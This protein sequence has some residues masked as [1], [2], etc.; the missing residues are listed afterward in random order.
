MTARVPH[1]SLKQSPAKRRFTFYIRVPI[2]FAIA[3]VIS[4][5]AAYAFPKPQISS[6]SPTSGPVGTSVPISGKNF[7][8]SQMNSR[9]GVFNGTAAT[10]SS[11]TRTTIV[12]SVPSAA[13]TGHV[14]VE[15]ID[16]TSNGG[17][18]GAQTA[19]SIT[20]L[21]PTSGPVGSSVTINGSNFGSSQGSSTVTF[22]GT[23]ATTID[24]WGS[25]Q[26]VAVVPTG[27]TTGNVVVTVGGTASNGVAFTLLGT[28]TITSLSPTSAGVGTP[29][30][31]KGT[32]FGSSQNSSTVTFNGTEA[33]TIN[34]WSGT[35]IV[36]VVPAEATTGDVV[37]TLDGVVSSNGVLF[38]LLTTPS[39]TSLSPTSGP[40]GHYVTITGKALGP[41]QG[42]ST[43]T[44]NGTTATTFSSWS[45]TSIVTFVP[46]GA[47]TGDVVVTVN[48][49]ASNG[50]KFTVLPTPNITSLSPK[51]GAI[52]TVVTIS[53]TEFGSTQGSSTVTFNGTPGTPS[54]WGSTSIKVA[55]P[56]GASSGMVLVTVGGIGSNGVLFTIGTT[57]SLTSLSPTSGP[58][59]APVT[60]TGTNFGSVQ[61]NSQVTFN[62]V[63]APVTSWSPTQ[64]TAQVP[65]LAT[66]G[67]VVVTVL[68]FAS[69]GI[70]FTV[71][72][73][74]GPS[75]LSVAPTAGLAGSAVAIT[76]S[77]FGNTQG[78][79]TVTFNGAA[80]TPT[81]W[82]SGFIMTTVPNGATSGN[83]V[84]TYGGVASNG[85]PYTVGAAPII[86]TNFGCCMIVGQNT[87][88]AG[89][90][91]GSS[92]GSSTI[93]VNG[94]AV[95]P[96]LW[97]NTD[98]NFKVPSNVVLGN[99]NTLV[100][101]VNGLPSNTVYFSIEPNIT[102]IT[103][104]AANQSA[105]VTINGTSFGATQGASSVA[106]G[107]Q[108]YATVTSWSNTSIVATV[109][110]SA[111]S[112]YADVQINGV[113]TGGSVASNYFPFIVGSPAPNITSLNPSS[114]PPLSSVTINGTNFLTY[115]GKVTFN[116]VSATTTNWT[117]T[118][119]TATVPSTATTGNVVVD[120]SGGGDNSNG[121]LFTVTSTPYI[122][123]LNPS[124]GGIGS[125]IEIQG[126]N[127]GSTQG[128]STV[129]VNGTVLP[130]SAITSWYNTAVYFTVPT[131]ATSG[132]VVVTV[133][134]VASN[135]VALTINSAPTIT[136]LENSEGYI[137]ESI[138]IVGYSFGATQGSST[139][140]FSGTS[141][142]VTYWS[143]TYIYA[144]V[145]NG[146]AIGTSNIV[147]TVGGVSSNS[148]PLT[149]IPSITSFSPTWGPVGTTV[150]VTGTNFGSTQGSSTIT[151]NSTTGTP[152]SWANTKIVVPVPTGATSGYVHVTESSL[153]SNYQ[154][155]YVGSAPTLTSI[156]PT[157]GPAGLYVTLTGTNFG[158]GGSVSFNGTTTS[159]YSQNG[160]S[161]VVAVPAGATTGNVTITPTG[162]VASNAVTFTV[163][164]G[165]GIT[166][167]NSANGNT[168]PGGG[169]GSSASI[170]GAGFGTSQGSSTVTFNG[171]SATPTYWNTSEIT[172][173]VPAGA[174]TGN[175][176]VTVG[177]I[178]S[179]AIAFTIYADPTVTSVSPTAA[180]PPASVTIT[181]NNF[182]ASQGNSYLCVPEGCPFGTVTSWSN[183]QI[184]VPISAFQLQAYG[185]GAPFDVTVNVDT[186]S[187]GI[188]SNGV[189]LTILP[190]ASITTI[191]PTSG[192][193]GT[194]VT[195]T[196]LGFGTTQS[197][198]TVSFNGGIATP[199]AWS[200]NSITV[201]VPAGAIAGPVIVTVNGVPANAPSNFSPLPV[202]TSISPTS[203]STNQPVTISG[204]GFG[205]A[206]NAG[207]T[208]GFYGCPG[209]G[210]NFTN[211][212][213]HPTSWSSTQIT[214]PVPNNAAT[215]PVSVY[216]CGGTSNSVNFTVPPNTSGTI[217][218][219]VTNALTTAAVAGITVA[220]QQSGSTVASV[221]T[222]TNGTYSLNNLQP[223]TYNIQGTG[224]GYVTVLITGATVTT[225]NTTTVNLVLS[226]APLVNSITPAWGGTGSVV[227]ISGTNFGPSQADSTGSVTFNGVSATPSSWNNSTITVPVPAS[228]T[229]GPTVVT[230]GGVL[231]NG[232]TFNVGGGSIGGTVTNAANGDAVSGAS[233]QALLAHVVQGTATTTSSGAYTIANLGPGT[234][235][236]V[237]SATGLGASVTTGE[238][239]TVGNTT[240]VNVALPA[241]GTDSGTVT[242]G[243]TGINNA[244]VSALRDGDAIATTTTSSSGSFT[245]ANLGAGTYSIEAAATGYTPET[246]NGVSITAGD[247]TTTNFALSGQTTLIYE[248]DALGR[249]AGVVDSLKGSGVYKYDAV[250][251]LTSIQRLS[252]SQVSVVS[253]SPTA[254]IAGTTV[255]ISGTN[256]SSTPSQDSV[257]FNG[258]GATVSAATTT[259]LTVTVPSAATSGA[260]KVT[261]PAGSGTSS[262]SFT[263]WTSSNNPAPSI[264]AIS[265]TLAA[266]GQTVTIT[267]TNFDPNS[268]NDGILLD[269][270]FPVTTASATPTTLTFVVPLNSPTGPVSVSNSAGHATSS[271]YLFVAP[272]PNSVTSVGYTGQINTIPGN[273]TVSLA[274]N[275][276]GILAFNATAGEP[277][278]FL[279][280]SQ[281][282]PNG[283]S[284]PATLIGPAGVS[285]Y[286]NSC[287]GWYSGAT[288][289]TSALPLNG[290]YA[291]V[292]GPDSGAAGSENIAVSNV[293]ANATG[294]LWLNGSV[295]PTVPVTIQNWGQDARFTF[296]ATAQQTATVHITSNTLPGMNVIV[297]GP[298]GAELASTS[299]GG[300]SFTLSVG[301]L[302]TTGSYLV[303]IVPDAGSQYIGSFDL[304]V[305]SP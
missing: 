101:T 158:T 5:S 153:N 208:G 47:T 266:V 66:T 174:S 154:Y 274:A 203:G 108:L 65:I 12:T 286:S 63:V 42:S 270:Q 104:D 54:S 24:S 58:V 38:T 255:T 285:V 139:V 193:V 304:S 20:S 283:C 44:F 181:G 166:Y 182:G 36:A 6:L 33:T 81:W 288:V 151:F 302:P 233:V 279:V 77:N 282:F 30:T 168:S 171:A 17:L 159:Y 48:G 192:D 244:T 298:N 206:I 110:S 106:F 71:T 86:A 264:T 155:F 235:D 187:S 3:A 145:P 96:T 94:T 128:S 267:G 186:S 277:L 258:V 4:P 19:P 246:V 224:T 259:Q 34:S 88:I 276:I 268:A 213:S 251:N 27:A 31:I 131:G 157:S 197:S 180:G 227:T 89:S 176:V 223:G 260:I 189:L 201:P 135:G 56:T 281:Q 183:T 21:T 160:T 178:A 164:P 23:A 170:I 120:A 129:S 82:S 293:L 198:S 114:G 303:D 234:Y 284:V 138:Q 125:S 79:S 248:Y 216:T 146:V 209:G 188:T 200:N 217:S 121:V 247:T 124:T 107:Y 26:I 83:V 254:G 14:V 185:N 257:T 215:G 32:N 231:S 68:G 60:L 91:F 161:T 199:T 237:V 136:Q 195:L 113:Y 74:P 25:A 242:N 2:L 152:S 175:V 132:N 16:G 29:I 238:A 28:P 22:N 11:L 93:A 84:V 95:T 130:S 119:I 57:P 41:T 39:I 240:T 55:V 115:G 272:S 9:P 112:G 256:F 62:G 207:A 85:V 163:T 287:F 73:S 98:I 59:G 1:S 211:T 123:A 103:P 150:T 202:I 99:T 289:E 92:Q 271:N 263:V 179:N 280:S 167:I 140:T 46:T 229:T 78:T 35:Q 253:F 169:I 51:L 72:S 294:Y 8:S 127:F 100:V 134:G 144:T 111:T 241:A 137:G 45:A 40:V 301:T 194:V 102:S 205:P 219:T 278:T 156:S 250:G 218:G 275:Q 97:N 80:A 249:L 165:P 305:T 75:I 252:T 64:I 142:A 290:T 143:A 49:T 300:S 245:I 37:V 239:V 53:G 269:G 214:V 117:D 212:N 295:G 87:G 148:E 262:T 172:V 243:T 7:I 228:A 116:G 222:P 220:A 299:Q 297:Y 296:N 149:I 196:G 52:G 236:V 291:L 69:N 118:A 70:S 126:S 50:V 204:S 273:Q 221:V 184:V 61:G 265:P 226:T 43:V 67:K 230:V 190:P 10:V 210:V 105:P 225:G 292:L 232:L 122:T 15:T 141:A 13:T 109:P 173:P 147:V 90:G 133:G 18:F 162:I 191:S 261:V 177:G 76:G